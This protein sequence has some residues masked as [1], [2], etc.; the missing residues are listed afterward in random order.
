MLLLD[1]PKRI[2]RNLS[3]DKNVTS[4]ITPRVGYTARLNQCTWPSSDLQHNSKRTSSLR[5]PGTAAVSA[6]LSFRNTT[7]IPL[8]SCFVFSFF[9]GLSQACRWV[10]L[11]S[12][13]SQP[14]SA[15]QTLIDWCWR[16]RLCTIP[17][18]G[19]IL[20]SRYGVMSGKKLMFVDHG[21]CV[22]PVKPATELQ[23]DKHV[24]INYASV[25]RT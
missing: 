8:T 2:K 24:I 20:T 7:R 5:R 16:W 6:V 3:L 13:Y 12:R 10:D 22:F 1:K 23:T 11:S 9:L 18:S 4:S 19:Q 15:R 25:R 21:L 14:Q 17:K